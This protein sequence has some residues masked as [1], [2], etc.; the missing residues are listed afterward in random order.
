MRR[1]SQYSFTWSRSHLSDLVGFYNEVAA[2]VDKGGTNDVVHLDFCKAL[3]TVPHHIYNTEFNIYGFESRTIWCM[4]NCLPICS[5]KAVVSSSMFRHRL[6][7]SSVSQASILGLLEF[8]SL[9]M[10]T[11]GFNAPSASLQMRHADA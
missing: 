6:V 3:D 4:N 7:A 11:V 5:Q 10:I 1:W 2:P 9:S 8:S